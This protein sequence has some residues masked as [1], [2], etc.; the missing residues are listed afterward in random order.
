MKASIGRIV[1]YA[2]G[3]CEDDTTE[4]CAAIVT[5]VT[6]SGAADLMIFTEGGSRYQRYVEYAEPV[7]GDTWHWPERVD[8]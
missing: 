4:C 6:D 1:H 3:T 7:A 2:M 8:G 5:K